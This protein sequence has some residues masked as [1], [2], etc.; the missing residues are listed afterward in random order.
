MVIM[1]DNKYKNWYQ[2]IARVYRDLAPQ[3]KSGTQLTAPWGACY[4]KQLPQ[5]AFARGP[6]WARIP[7]VTTILPPGT[8]KP[9]GTCLGPNSSLLTGSNKLPNILC[10]AL[11]A[12]R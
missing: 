10:A 6:S 1:P 12:A 9:S 8:S 11:A 4:D 3:T 5:S 2:L 7:A